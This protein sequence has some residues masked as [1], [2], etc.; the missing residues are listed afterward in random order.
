MV[1]Q[2]PVLAAGHQPGQLSAGHQSY[3]GVP[4]YQWVQGGFGSQPGVSPQLK[5]ASG[6]QSQRTPNTTSHYQQQGYGQQPGVPDSGGGFSGIAAAP[7]GFP[8]GFGS[9]SEA[10]QKPAA[11]DRSQPIPDFGF[12]PPHTAL[13]GSRSGKPQAIESV[14]K[15]H[16]PSTS[17]HMSLS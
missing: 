17:D 2:N 5:D 6:F 4:G 16:I 14:G 11:A 8:V 7:E 10:I 13:S 15:L 1:S 9:G 12:G 3:A